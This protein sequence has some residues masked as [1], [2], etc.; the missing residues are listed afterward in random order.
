VIVRGLAY[1]GVALVA[2][3]GAALASRGE[4]GGAGSA[5]ARAPS[6]RGGGLEAWTTHGL[7]KV[8]PHDPPR[9]GGPPRLLAAR[10]EFEPFQLVLRPASPA[11]GV[12]RVDVEAD[13]LVASG[14]ARI[15]AR[16]VA[17]YLE[18][19]VA[20]AER[21]SVDGARGEWPDALLPRVDAYR[22]ERR[23]AFPF[24]LRAGRNQ[25]LWIE[26]Y[27]PTD[28]AAGLYRGGLRVSAGGRPA[29]VVPWTLEVL[30]IELPSTSTLRSSFGFSGIAA[31][32]AHRGGYTD[33]E[34]L[35]RLTELYARAALR[36]R[37][38]LHGGSFVPPPA[39]F[40]AGAAAVDWTAWERELG[41]FLDGSVF[42]PADPL[43]GARIT[44]FDVRTAA[45]L[46]EA[47][48]VAYWRAWA[49]HLRARGALDR[50]FLYLWDEP[51]EGDY[52][53]VRRRAMLARA[54]DPALRTLLT[55]QLEPELE[56]AVDLWTPLVNCLDE[57]TGVEKDCDRIVPRRAYA[58][59]TRAGSRLWWYQS[60]SSH[61]CE[62]VGGEAFRVWPSYVIDAPAI[63]HR[64]LP[65]LAFRH[66][67]EGE[68]YYNTVEAWADAADPWRDLYRHGGN[69]DGT[70]F[71]PGTPAAI[72]GATDAPIESLRLK[73]IRE[74]LEDHE[75]LVQLAARAGEEAARRAAAPV[76]TEPHRWT[77]EPETLYLARDRI[78]RE[79]A[80]TRET[81]R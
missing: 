35:Y 29:L 20:L 66:G 80:R 51:G 23:S 41:P 47:Q 49:S 58:G 53:A 36:H 68:L 72:G 78:A 45:G 50:A 34:D 13:D 5:A 1:G 43:P 71:Y 9:A 73:L 2:V 7:D 28:T 69:G 37:L 79:L 4:P 48:T 3:V 60:C 32:R 74:G 18:R 56:G 15:P 46:D 30:P 11:R 44:S 75:Y 55:E 63:A 19:Y 27:V 24:D 39:T 21:S 14:G 52:P 25:P 40:E 22:G 64:V 10:N 77:R 42:G 62:G 67:V 17:I 16:H 8:R 70:L 76:G 6:L 26:V 54:A 57:R 59:A 65:W 81:P 61:G 12:G 33:D 38:S 31:L